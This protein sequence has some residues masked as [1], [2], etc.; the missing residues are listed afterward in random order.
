MCYVIYE[1]I[2]TN[3]AEVTHNDK[4]TNREHEQFLSLWRGAAAQRRRLP[5]ENIYSTTHALLDNRIFFLSHH[6]IG[7]N[8]FPEYAPPPPQQSQSADE[9]C[10]CRSV[11]STPSFR[12]SL[13]ALIIT[14]FFLLLGDSFIIL[15]YCN[16][17][18]NAKWIPWTLRWK[19]SKIYFAS[20][21]TWSQT[22]GKYAE[23]WLV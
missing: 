14:G 13:R 10:I 22:N 15:L 9:F 23:G 17:H 12:P 8:V 18:D 19:I 3:S 6:K 20:M 11:D 16:K 1:N 21:A 4:F 5:N 2:N 7:L